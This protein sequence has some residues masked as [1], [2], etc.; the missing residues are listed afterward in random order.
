[1]P[2]TY[3]RYEPDMAAGVIVAGGAAA[4]TCGRR[5][6]SAALDR[7]LTWDLQTGHLLSTFDIQRDTHA[8]VIVHH[9]KQPLLAVGYH[10][11]R[12]DVFDTE[13]PHLDLLH[14][15]SVHQAAISALLFATDGSQLYS[16]S[17]KAEL[18][19]FSLSA[20]RPLYRLPK[21]HSGPITAL[22]LLDD[23]HLVSASRDKVVIVWSLTD[24]CKL[25]TLAESITEARALATFC[26]EGEQSTAEWLIFAGGSDNVIHCWSSVEL[27]PLPTMKELILME[28]DE[29][30]TSG[31]HRF[32]QLA[33]EHG[34]LHGG[35]DVPKDL[36]N[37]LERNDTRSIQVTN[38]MEEAESLL[39]SRRRP[40][41]YL[42]KM[43]R[44]II[45]PTQTM[46]IISGCVP[47]DFSN[48]ALFLTGLHSVELYSLLTLKS[49]T[50]QS[51]KRARRLAR[52]KV[53][54]V[55]R[56]LETSEA[57]F[58]TEAAAL[59]DSKPASFQLS[60]L[61]SSL[62]VL[63]APYGGKL[64][65]ANWLPLSRGIYV[66]TNENLVQV[67]A[68]GVETKMGF[69]P[70]VDKRVEDALAEVRNLTYDETVEIALPGHR[71]PIHNISL[72]SDDTLAITCSLGEVKVWSMRRL[73]PVAT[74][75]LPNSMKAP[76]HARI[77]P[78]NQFSVAT[79]TVGSLV[80]INNRTLEPIDIIAAH[81]KKITAL[82]VVSGMLVT[83]GEDGY[84]RYWSFGLA[85]E[86][87]TIIQE[88]QFNAGNA[89]TTIAFD[90][91]GKYIFVALVDNTV[92]IHF[93][94][95]LRF[96]MVLYGHSLPITGI[97][98]SANGEKLITC[99]TDKTL[100]IWGLQFGECQKVLRGDSAF[101]S[102]RL[103]RDTHL[104]LAANKA[105]RL[106]YWDMDSHQL[107]SVLG[108]G[109]Y[110]A[111]F[112]R[113]HFGECTGLVVSSTG[114]FAVSVGQDGAI[115]QWLQ[116]EELISV[117][118]EERKRLEEAFEAEANRKTVGWEDESI[119]SEAKNAG[120]TI[121]EAVALVS[122]ELN[123]GH[124][125]PSLTTYGQAPL[126][127][128]IR[129]LTVTVRHETLYDALL[130]I[131]VAA[132]LDLLKL[133]VLCLD[134]QKQPS[135]LLIRCLL[136]LIMHY[137]HHS[138]DT[139]GLG[140]II[141]SAQSHITTLLK[142]QEVAARTVLGCLRLM[143]N[144]GQYNEE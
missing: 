64:V 52:Q 78:G 2:R 82:E 91:Q 38:V 62:L 123:A 85:D 104:A 47:K 10:D 129:T 125:G 134:H 135:D 136:H 138:T 15:Y 55:L 39:A 106:T 4:S 74:I 66:A 144:Y 35:H 53:E 130:S 32:V 117:E 105:G 72:N 16:A 59:L 41:V 42:G 14:T 88:R 143:A 29:T 89:I 111:L 119:T 23:N 1:M 18:S 103:I 70:L 17:T 12:V 71:H 73:S 28:A 37:A 30:A 100:R 107:I 34:V 24:R 33:E 81:T 83:A 114:R 40:F 98:V 21:E 31:A 95:S 133:L 80:L 120:D 115:R 6:F 75:V 48:P 69:V 44:S 126:D 7:I 45:E 36:S 102:V 127:Y 43:E 124:T 68:L 116:S 50:A 63:R 101:T 11:G 121:M 26:F 142:S 96:H 90:P 122:G 94:D 54:K 132:A 110:G 58:K 67:Y 60:H 27:P 61:L 57:L 13:T 128:L 3:L 93:A 113:G 56:L 46:A 87:L 9:Q 109:N 79:D 84:V 51:L 22:A 20:G 86:G 76:T 140:P 131:T 97:S 19:C 108:E 65:S 92:R 139:Q 5:L 25:Q 49:A 77:L 118:S 8:T 137:F 141:L 112:A 99:S